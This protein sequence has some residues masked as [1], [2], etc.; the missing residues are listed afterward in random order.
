METSLVERLEK[1]ACTMLPAE[2]VMAVECA[3]DAGDKRMQAMLDYILD[4]GLHEKELCTQPYETIVFDD[5]VLLRC[6][7]CP[8]LAAL[9]KIKGIGYG[10]TAEEARRNA[11]FALTLPVGKKVRTFGEG[12]VR[13]VEVS[14]IF[15]RVAY[16]AL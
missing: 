2:T 11:L 1:R 4:C 13:A 5:R 9:P 10:K 6:A 7:G 12:P 14:C 8:R 3:A 15:N 16:S